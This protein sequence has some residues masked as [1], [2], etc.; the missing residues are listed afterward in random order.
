MMEDN[1]MNKW[2]LDV[3]KFGKIE[4]A[5]IEVSPFMVFVG[6]NNSGKSYIME[7]LWGIIV[8]AEKIVNGI[9]GLQQYSDFREQY[10]DLISQAKKEKVKITVE[11]QKLLIDFFNMSLQLKKDELIKKIFNY[12]IS[13]DRIAIRRNHYFDFSFKINE[14]SDKVISLEN[15]DDIEPKYEMET[16][17]QVILFCNDKKIGTYRL[18]YN[19][20]DKVQLYNRVFTIITSHFLLYLIRNEYFNR[21]SRYSSVL[22]RSIIEKKIPLYFPASRTGF[23]H[24]YRAIIGNQRD[25]GETIDGLELEFNNIETKNQIAGTTLTLPTIMYLEKLQKLTI[26]PDNQENYKNEIQ[27]LTEKILEGKISKNSFEQYEF[28]SNFSETGIPLHVTSSL[29]SELAPIVLFLSSSY[30][31]NLWIVEE[32]ESHL[33]PK[34]QMEVARLLFRMLNK[35]KSIW[36]T[37]HSDSLMQKINNLVTLS[38]HDNKDNIMKKLHFEKEDIIEDVS[39]VNVYQFTT[40]QGITNVEKLDLGLYGYTTRTFN[41]A[42]KQLIIETDEIQNAGN[43]I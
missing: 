3:Q 26:D 1:K 39:C 25:N 11:F 38:R 14:I 28:V 10:D 32:I 21:Y 43:D 16:F 36:I 29:V 40:Q 8:E 24:T 17:Y 42:L 18:K 33:H 12:S 35:N 9:S 15:E 30:D 13:A 31:P 2:I 41:D 23:M 37:T 5:S 4:S 6:D 20:F 34:I 22:F 27:F 19:D 7:L